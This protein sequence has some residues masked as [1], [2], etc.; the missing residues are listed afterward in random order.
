[1]SDRRDCCGA[2]RVLGRGRSLDFRRAR[3][4]AM[5]LMMIWR[6]L[7]CRCTWPPLPDV[8]CEV[9][10]GDAAE[11]LDRGQLSSA[12]ASLERRQG[13][14]CRCLK[15]PTA[16]DGGRASA[17]TEGRRHAALRHREDPQDRPSLGLSSPQTKGRQ[18]R[19]PRM[20]R[21]QL[22]VS[23]V[24]YGVMSVGKQCG[25]WKPVGGCPA[26]A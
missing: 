17:R 10:V 22:T 15:G 21:R 16:F 26:G 12:R 4:K 24:G 9:D 2:L 23:N 8:P 18:L 19:R 5:R 11:F 14:G 25:C 3:Q 7:P 1:V 13:Q 6:T 20:M